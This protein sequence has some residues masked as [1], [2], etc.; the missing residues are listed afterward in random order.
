MTR[1]RPTYSL[2]WQA[3][4]HD[5]QQVFEEIR[6]QGFKGSARLVRRF[7][8]TLREKC[9]PLTEL[10]PPQ[11]FE[12][13]S[14][15]KAVWLFIREQTALTPKEQE[16]LTFI[17]QASPTAELAYGL[18][19]DFL[20][21]VRKREARTLGE[22]DRSRPAECDCRVTKLCPWDPQG[23]INLIFPPAFHYDI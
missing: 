19:Q 18:V 2:R 10:A 17:R 11:P 3:G 14:A 20:M 22:L 23:Q 7:L 6:A 21:M 4:I 13:F 1:M 8:Q 9:R 16:D 5:G 12:Q 15:R